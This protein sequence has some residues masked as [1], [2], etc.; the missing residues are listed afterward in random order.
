MNTDLNM[1]TKFMMVTD[2]RVGEGV[3]LE[4]KDQVN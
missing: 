1:Q 3:R 4:I 2:V